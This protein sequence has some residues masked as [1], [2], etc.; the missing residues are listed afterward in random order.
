MKQAGETGVLHRLFKSLYFHIYCVYRGKKGETEFGY[1][2]TPQPPWFF[3]V[4]RVKLRDTGPT[5]LNKEA[6]LQGLE[7][8]QETTI[9][10]N[11]R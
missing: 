5:F 7:T 8:W 11:R 2:E 9:F 6:S 10:L 3:Y 1:R 4:P